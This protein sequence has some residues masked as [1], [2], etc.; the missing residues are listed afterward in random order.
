MVRFPPLALICLVWT[1]TM[2]GDCHDFSAIIG[3][4]MKEKVSV[5]RLSMT[6]SFVRRQKRLD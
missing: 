3:D 1:I 2:P 4:A 5:Q 6:V